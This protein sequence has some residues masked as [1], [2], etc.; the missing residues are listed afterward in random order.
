MKKYLLI[1]TLFLL[2][3]NLFAQERYWTAYNF[4][5]ESKDIETV[6]KIAND[7]F[8]NPGSKADGVTVYLF[9]NHFSDNDN[10]FTHSV[11]FRGTLDAMG[12]QYSPTGGVAQEKFQAFQTKISQFAKA[13]SSSFGK[14]LVTL[15]NSSSNETYPVQNSRFL[16]V[17]D[18]AKFAASW[19]KMEETIGN[20]S[21]SGSSKILGEINSG[22]SSSGATHYVLRSYPNF[23]AALKGAELPT[24]K[25]KLDAYNA[26]RNETYTAG[27]VEMVRTST[28][29]LLGK[30]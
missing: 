22:V 7:F 10:N 17:T 9:E 15:S 8:S 27:I 12:N 6:A 29:I 26:F 14:E 13:H 28:R 25:V 1:T 24:D 11:V 23:K 3:L 19:K 4:S 2:S 16:K 5:V 30:W 18:P 20:Y 21:E